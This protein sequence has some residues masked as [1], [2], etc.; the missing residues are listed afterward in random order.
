MDRLARLPS[1]YPRAMAFPA[2]LL[3]DHETVVLDLHPHWWFFGPPAI[4][5]GGSLFL[6]LVATAQF[7]GMVEDLLSFVLIASIVVSAAWLVVQLVKWRT[8][9]FVVT[10]DRLIYRE[11][12]IARGGV[13]IPLQ[14]V[15]NVNF[16]QGILER[17]LRVGDLLIESG[18]SDGQQTFTD[19]AQ[20]EKVQNIIQSTIRGNL[21]GHTSIGD[22]TA[23]ILVGPSIAEELERLV[24]LRDRGAISE[25]EFETLKRRLLS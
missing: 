2:R 3:N 21:Q 6:S 19:I 12:V 5:F 13:E 22:S 15:N 23:G 11:G 24:A 9:Y 20:P 17:M 1:D 4:M 14:R 25:D 8:T 18:G 7:D 16:S 10:S